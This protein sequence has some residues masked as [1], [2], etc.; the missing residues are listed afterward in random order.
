ML[1]NVLDRIGLFPFRREG[2]RPGEGWAR[3]GQQRVDGFYITADTHYLRLNN[4]TRF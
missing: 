1:Y 4:M 3:S 2:F